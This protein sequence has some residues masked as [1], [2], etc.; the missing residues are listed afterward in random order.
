MVFSSPVFLFI[1]LPLCILSYALVSYF[2]NIK[3][4]NVCLLIF[5]IL[6]YAYGSLDF[7]PILLISIVINY[8]LSCIYVKAK[9]KIVKKRYFIAAIAF[10]VLMLFIYKYLNLFSRVLLGENYATNIKLP[11][12]ISFYTFQVLSYH[13]DVYRRSVKKSNSLID[14]ALFTM[15]FPQLIAGPIVRY[16][17]IDD[18]LKDRTVS[19]TQ[20]SHGITRFMVGFAKKILLANA[21]GKIADLAFDGMHQYT[22]GFALSMFS[23]ICYTMQI[24]LDFSAYSDMAI[25]IGEVFG[26]EFPE[27]FNMPFLSKSLSE[28]WRRWHITLS[29]FFGDYVYKPLGGSRK[30]LA[31]T[32]LNIAIVFALSGFWHGA[33]FNFLFWGLYNALFLIIERLIT[34]KTSFKFENPILIIYA[35]LVWVVGMIIFRFESFYALQ[36]FIKGLFSAPHFNSDSRWL[37]QAIFTP[38]FGLIFTIS[39]LYLTPFFDKIYSTFSKSRYGFIIIDIVVVIFFIYAIME[40]L[41]TGYNPFIYFRF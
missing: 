35:N 5:S 36:V 27:N 11:N 7:L 16:I 31:R 28:F 22:L 34:T 15:L 19:L 3:A 8:Y 6:F 4:L 18:K 17:S 32:C 2:K 40:M 29:S 12:G 26:F 23:I 20:A 41:T 39:V 21:L 1:F 9:K 25:G 24:Y 10:N 30:G 13:I 37:L 14:F 33:N 38:Y